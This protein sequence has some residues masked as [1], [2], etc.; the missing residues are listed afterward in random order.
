LLQPWTNP[1]YLNIIFRDNYQLSK[2]EKN[3]LSFQNLSWARLVEAKG[4]L[5]QTLNIS[6]FSLPC[7]HLQPKF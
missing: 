2:I 4:I 6:F 3:S 5:K 7:C 1:L